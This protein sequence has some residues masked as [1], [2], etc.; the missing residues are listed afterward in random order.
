MLS[1]VDKNSVMKNTALLLFLAMCLIQWFV[2][3]SMIF[4]QEETIQ[5]GQAFKFKTRP[6]D[7][8][9]PFRGKY[10]TL[11]YEADKI[12]YNSPNDWQVGEPIFVKIKED[13]AGFAIIE[14]LERYAPED[15]DD[16]ISTTI[17]YVYGKNPTTVTINY[18]FERYYMEES[19]A[20]KAEHLVRDLAR[21]STSITYSLV[22][23]HQ[24]KAALEDVLV[25]GVS[26]KTAVEDGY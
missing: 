12:S 23:I 9:D 11:E 2:P 22:V 4:Q 17:K 15:T 5:N 16:Y 13:N 19:K 14:G 18:P 26:I 1:L 20:L 25:D 8:N 24:G 10:I 3:I 6:I 7:P 21:D